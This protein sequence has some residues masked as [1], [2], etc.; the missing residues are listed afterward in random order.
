[1][2]KYTNKF[3][4]P[5][6]LEIYFIFLN[7]VSL[8]EPN[9]EVAFARLAKAIPRRPEESN[10]L[11]KEAILIRAAE[12]T[13]S[14]LL[15]KYDYHAFSALQQHHIHDNSYQRVTADP[16]ESN[17]SQRSSPTARGGGG[18][19]DTPAVTLSNGANNIPVTSYASNDPGSPPVSTPTMG[20]FRS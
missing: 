15:R 13:E 16:L 14:M 6:R 19:P 11:P 7:L 4:V 20:K 10:R 18:Y 17:Y 12:I 2:V 8:T 3:S 9:L 5:F 1:M